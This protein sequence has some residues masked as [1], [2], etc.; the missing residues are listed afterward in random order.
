MHETD[1]EYIAISPMYCGEEY[2]ITYSRS[3]EQVEK[4]VVND[5]VTWARLIFF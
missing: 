1:E 3:K 4:I 2:N 5:F